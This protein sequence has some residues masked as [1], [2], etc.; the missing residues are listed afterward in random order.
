ML[1]KA[2]VRVNVLSGGRLANKMQGHDVCFVTMKGAVTGRILTKP[3]MYIPHGEGVLL[4][5][6]IGGAPKNPA[7]YENL[8]VHPDVQV[9]HRGEAMNLT[10][11]LADAAEKPSL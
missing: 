1:A 8:V 9:R 10:A 11:R 5:A 4:V 6:S 2:H 3:L 7:W